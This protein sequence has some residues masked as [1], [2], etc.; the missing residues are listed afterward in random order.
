MSTHLSLLPRTLGSNQVGVRE[1][2]ERVLLQALRLHGSQPKADLARL[3]SLSTQTAS[4][5]VDRLL[6]EELIERLEA[7]R[8]RIGQPSRPVALRPDAAF[9]VGIKIDRRSLDVLLLDFTGEV[10]WQASTVYPAPEVEAVFAAIGAHLDGIHGFLGERA[11]RL[12]GIGL[13]APLM[14]GGW[15]ELLGM[16]REAAEAWRRVDMRAR[17]QAMT[18]L[19]VDFAKD[20]SAACVAEL[21][22]GRG[23]SMENYLYV[24]VD[25]LV[26]GGL[27]I[28]SQPHGGRHGNAGAIGS[29]PVA[30]S[31]PRAQPPRQLL[32]EAS[33]VTLEHMLAQAGLAPIPFTDAR[34]LEAPWAPVTR[35]WIARA[36][37]A[38]AFAAGSAACLLDLDGVIVDGA[39]SRDL[40]DALLEAVGA[41]MDGYD[42]QGVLRPQV[43]AGETGADAKVC[44]A[45]WLPLHREF[46]P[47]HDL[48]LKAA[49]R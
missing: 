27:V 24:F 1:Y 40:L 18:P 42:W 11:Q 5:I 34:S 2:N 19:P 28:D 14:F 29:M 9:S 49:Q 37:D 48:L 30:L 44:G 33:L 17:L 15:Q 31:G 7:R 20:T 16:E 32:A 35:A 41:A 45:A 26:G 4:V 46:A 36:A 22:A 13:A 43:L 38:I 23:R 21:V 25:I 8:G 6:K 39:V 10:R 47:A 3:T 12:V